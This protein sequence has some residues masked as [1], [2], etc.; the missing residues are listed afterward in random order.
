MITLFAIVN[1]V[2]AQDI[3][4]RTDISQAIQN[5]S[6]LAKPWVFWYWMYGSY[7]KEGITADLEGMKEAGI[8]GA[9]LM[10][11]EGP[12]D[13][14]LYKPA[15]EQLSPEWWE[16]VTYAMKEAKRLD[17]EL[18]MH[19]SDGFAT[20]GGPWI[21]PEESMQKVVWSKTYPEGGKIISDTLSQPETNEGYYKDIAVYAY[22]TPEGARQNSYARQVM[23]TSS[24][25]KPE[26]DPQLLTTKGNEEEFECEERC[27]IQYEFE[28]PFT[29]RS[30]TIHTGGSNYQPNR[31]R[32]QVSDDGQHFRSIGQLQPPRHGWLDWDAPV[33]HA[34]EATTARY[35]RFVYDP[36]G[37]EPGAEDLDDAKWSP[38]LEVLG[39]EL[40]G[41]PRIHQFEGKTGAVWRVSEQT[42]SG[43]VPDS[44]SVPLDKMI[45]I[46]EYLNRDGTLDWKVPEGAWTILRMGHTST[47]HTNSTGGGGEGLEV[48]K[49]N[50]DPIRKQFDRWYGEAIRQVGPELASEVLKIFHIDSWEAGSQNWSPVFREEFRKRRGYDPLTYL[51]AMAGIPVESA[52]VS[53]RFLYDIRKTIAELVNDVFFEVVARQVHNENKMFSAESVSP[54][55]TSDGMLHFKTVDIPMGEFWLR[56]PTHDKP[57]D[58]LDAISAGH[59]YG[60]PIIQAEAFTEVRMEWDE[61]PAMLKALGDRNYALGINRF[62]YHVFTH[63]PWPERGPGMTLSGVGLLFQPGQT[64]WEPGQAWVD[65]AHRSQALLQQGK[66]VADV[67]VFTGEEVP[68]RSLLPNRLVP[69]LP[70]IFGKKVVQQQKGRLAN[71]GQP[72]Q[73]IPVGVDNSAN[74]AEAPDWTDPLRGYTYDSI[75]RDALLNLATV[76]NGQIVL[77]GGA[78]YKLLVLPGSRRMSLHA[79]LMTPEIAQR[80]LEL[81]KEGATLLIGEQALQAPGLQDY[82]ASDKKVQNIMRELWKGAPEDL[83][84]MSTWKVGKGKIVKGPYKADT[85]DRLGISRDVEITDSSN[86]YLDDFAW[87]HRADR[88]K[89]MDVYFISNQRSRT[90]EFRLSLRAGGRVPEIYNAVTG[91]LR[92]AEKW[93]IENGRTQLPLKLPPNGSIFIILRKQAEQDNSKG[94]NW[95]TLRSVKEIEGTWK[96][97]FDPAEGGPADTISFR[98][99]T[100]WV[101]RQDSSIR[102]YSGTAEYHNSFEW[103]KAQSK[104][105]RVWLDLGKVA[106]IA[107]VTVNGQDCGVAWTPPYRV[108]V[109]K[110]LGKGKN[111][112]KIAVTN[113]WRNRII[114]DHNLPEDEQ[115]S[116]LTDPVPYLLEGEPLVQ[117]GLLGPVTLQME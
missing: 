65:Y 58:M 1:R 90:R 35:F 37:S 18:A 53:E 52:E 38:D 47:G 114:R 16:M 46:T 111:S 11:I 76:R 34:L 42:T 27:W 89:N 75:N 99:L 55:M 40:S 70:G 29:A 49:F 31:L 23:V 71:Q 73:E 45:N 80:T 87:T 15:I 57:N 102:Y 32:I 92:P 64:W 113:T 8:G 106:N 117:S 19:V 79:E 60:K 59:V 28:K 26:T 9:Y 62:V 94:E 77:P 66:P 85:F 13:P 116:F 22:P 56:S 81:V 51:P 33:A 6:N 78:R 108:D 93:S 103:D 101:N 95:L 36:K 96:V 110:A 105:K 43:Q 100:D 72:Q 17:L 82:P 21:K 14:P 88:A 63:N 25:E 39:I 67:A 44:L 10:P 61:H 115:V 83:Q 84:P 98:N 91:E 24:R 74:I 104:N 7:S 109:T 112:I 5:P 4:F 41:A 12:Q 2:N 48:D 3:S 97:T 69:T 50:P 54:T 86:R 30:L 68:R 20:A 107:R